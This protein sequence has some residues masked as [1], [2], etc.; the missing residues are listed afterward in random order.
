[1]FIN[2]APDGPDLFEF[3]DPIP[4]DLAP[5]E[6]EKRICTSRFT[7]SMPGNWKVTVD[8]FNEAYHLQLT[9]VATE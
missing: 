8:A 3:L 9:G 5:F 6:L 4:A 7:I 2:P 1:M